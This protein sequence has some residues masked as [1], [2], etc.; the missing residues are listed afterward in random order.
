MPSSKNY[1][2]DYAQERKTAIARGEAKGPDS[3]H[4]K[5]LRARRAA[6][7]KG[8]VGKGQDWDHIKM[9]SKGGSNSLK[10]GRPDTPHDNRSFPRNPDGSAKSN[11]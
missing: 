1:Q 5:R 8:L 7:A 3:G 6:V 2:R 10:N 9:L 11:R 4:T